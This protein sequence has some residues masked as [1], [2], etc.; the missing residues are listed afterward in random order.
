M[1]N[2]FR[3][4]TLIS[5]RYSLAFTLVELLIVLA[6]LSVLV[7]IALVSFRSSQ[8][9]G[10]DA[11]RKS[12]LKQMSSA[13]E[14]FYSDYGKYPSASQGLI[15]GC[16]YNY[17][18]GVGSSCNWGNGEFGDGRTLYFKTIPKDPSGTHS[19]YYRIVDSPTNQKFQLFAALENSQDPECLAGNCSSPSINY[20][21]GSG[22]TCNFAITSPNTSATE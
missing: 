12:D 2:R 7:S 15:Q 4:Y 9:R 13:L 5:R 6:I 14:L 3:N 17:S 20:Q 21:C 8:A 16:T 18:T 19:Y 11:Q 1:K 22:V 10:R